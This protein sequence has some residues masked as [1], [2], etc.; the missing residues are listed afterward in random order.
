MSEAGFQPVEE[1]GEVHSLRAQ[2]HRERL[3][4]S[5]L[6]HVANS[7]QDLHGLMREATQLLH[8]WSGCDAVGIRLRE[9]DDFPYF[10][11][12]GFPPEF[13][14]AENSLCVHDLNGQVVRDIQGNP[15]LE[16]MCG[17]VLC[18]RFNP[19]LP[20]FTPQ[21]SFWTNS[22]TRLLATTS[23]ADRQART[24]NRCHGEGF[25]SVALI[26]LRSGETTLGL[27][28]MND[29]R[30]GRFTEEMIGLLENLAAALGEAIG[31]RQA[32]SLLER[33]ESHFRL[34]YE[35]APLGYQSL[36]IEGR[37]IE[38]NQAWLD[39][40]G[41][42][43]EEVL[44]RSFGDFLPPQDVPLFRQR[45][46]RFKQI[47]E[48]HGVEFDMVRKDGSTITVSIDGRIMRN[49]QGEFVRTHCILHDIADRKRAEQALRD[50]E[51]LLNRAEEIAGIGS[52]IWDLTNDALTWSKGMVSLC[53]L[54]EG[55][56]M[57]SLREAIQQLVH[58]EDRQRVG[59][60]IR[61]MIAARRARPMEFRIVRPDGEERILQSA[62]E[63]VLND[64][65]VPIRCVGILHDITRRRADESRL[66]ALQLQLNHASRLAT[67]GELTAGIAHEVNQPLCAIVN[68]AK[69]C[70]NLAAQESPNRE[71]I[72]Q[73]SDAIA[74]AASRSGE[75]VRQ[76]SAFSRRS[77]GEYAAVPVQQLVDEAL[78]LIRLDAHAKEVAFVRQM[79][80]EDAIV[81][82]QPVRIHQVLVN[83][84]RNA[85]EALGQSG[86]GPKQVLVRVEPTVEEVRISVEDNGPGPGSVNL[87]SL[88]EPFYTTKREGLGMGLSISRTIVEE[89]GGRIRAIVNSSG[90]LTVSFTLKR[91]TGS[92]VP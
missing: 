42:S 63:F 27:L 73:W 8:E 41:Y 7:S 16:C 64:Q 17:N 46:P 72:S 58:P 59:E 86:R 19:A 15:V 68:F 34:L 13:V 1:S 32:N 21:G 54:E 36:D 77:P 79:P 4:T 12:L 26:P 24:R 69:A 50:R 39:L 85:V 82:V 30:P 6:L 57:G 35:N 31:R 89:H 80:D 65:G 3:L 55:T 91:R 47:G 29:R 48:V 11:T 9:G 5:R 81:R 52:F 51:S 83:L 38:V 2:L 18:G 60:E 75:I 33:R 25:E 78:L 53:G 49:P 43:H 70:K 40:L 61:Q 71:L 92:Q 66:A 10:E 44:G 62:G 20:F 28:Q 37:L 87:A 56:V 23:E 22:T 84:L 74:A 14:Q 67:L 88:F 90:G 45:F 76:L